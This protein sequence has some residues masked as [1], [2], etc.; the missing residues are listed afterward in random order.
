MNVRYGDEGLTL[1]NCEG[2]N[3]PHWSTVTF[4]HRVPTYTG[5]SNTVHCVCVCVRRWV[6][7][8]ANAHVYTCAHKI[9]DYRFVKLCFYFPV[10]DQSTE[11]NQTVV[12]TLKHKLIYATVND[13]FI[14]LQ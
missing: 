4:L 14:F 9:S 3:W 10:P 1:H 13:C 5:I 11:P 8:C 2:I 12:C 7:G 6:G